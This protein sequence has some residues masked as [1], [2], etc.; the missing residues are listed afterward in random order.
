MSQRKH[1]IGSL[2][3]I[4]LATTPAMAQG[5]PESTS[6][7]EA[8]LYSDDMLGLLI[9]WGLIGM[10]FVSIGYSMHLFFTVRAKTIN[11]PEFYEQVE[12]LINERQYR[13]AREAAGEEKSYLG[14]LVST[15]VNEAGN[16]YSAMERA[17]E[18]VGD[19]ETTR[20]LRPL[21]YLSVLGNISPMLGLFGTVYGMI[22]AFQKLVS[23]GGKPDPAELASGISTALV[24]TFWGLVVAIP[25]LAFY[26]LIRNRIDALTSEGMVQAE[27]L[28]SAFKPSKSK[29]S[30]STG[31]DGAGKES[32]SSTGGSASGRPRA[33]P[34]PNADES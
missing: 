11:P 4:L 23:A 8:F 29:K 19:A 20:M 30:A 12:T 13:E 1:W 26:A 27:E 28:I 18:E 5:E 9:I 21:E 17:I 32:A 6:W 24:T 31:K 3:L 14:K 34:K 2:V 7:A 22:L 16:G 33:T 10:S 25:A 15:A